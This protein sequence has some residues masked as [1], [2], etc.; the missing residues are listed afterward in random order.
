LDWLW[1]RQ[2]LLARKRR[3]TI[4]A[5]SRHR[6]HTQT[7]LSELCSNHSEKSR[8]NKP[9]RAAPQAVDTSALAGYDRPL[10]T[11]MAY[12][13]LNASLLYRYCHCVRVETAAVGR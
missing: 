13:S 8:Q 4:D 10:A 7:H 5:I 12:D 1:S 9:K 6:E 11:L 2:L 3:A